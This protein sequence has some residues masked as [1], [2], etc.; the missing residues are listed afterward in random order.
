MRR[1]L[2]RTTRTG[3]DRACRC[4]GHGWPVGGGRACSL[5]LLALDKPWQATTHDPHRRL[6]EQHV[7]VGNRRRRPEALP[8]RLR[9]PH[10]AGLVEPALHRHGHQPLCPRA[11]GP[12]DPLSHALGQLFRLL[13]LAGPRGHLRE[14]PGHP[15]PSRRHG[16]GDGLVPSDGD[17]L[18][19]HNPRARH[20]APLPLGRAPR[21]TEDPARAS[22]RAA[23]APDA[24]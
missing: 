7:H 2:V 16:A 10:H 17:A 1:N 8:G 6:S 23:T 13:R 22:H 15:L 19:V 14:L 18:H 12:H 3:R 20:G 21:L 11:P 24:R 9:R 4:V 5:R